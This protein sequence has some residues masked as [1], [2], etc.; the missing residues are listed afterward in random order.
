[1]IIAAAAAQPVTNGMPFNWFDA[2]AVAVLGFGLFRGRRNGMSKE[3]L[4]LLEWLVLVPLCGLAY[5]LLGGLMSGFVTDPLWNGL[6]AY[7]SLAMVVFITFTILKHQLAEKLVKS[8]FFKSGEYYMGMLA[9]MVRYVCVLIFV[10]ALLNAPVYTAA[11][12]AA[13]RARDQ[14]NFGGGA[15][16][17][18][19][20]NY[21]PHLSTI[22]AGVFKESFLGPR[23]E[24]Y[25]GKL[26]INTGK[27]G[28][29]GSQPGKGT[30]AKPK[31]I[32]KIG[33]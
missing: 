9:G 13:Q 12:I 25:A 2:V 33:Y 3:L 20:G 29:N 7:L 4:P 21:F 28:A 32:I 22:Q 16:S 27:L 30:P 18:F 14:Q 5:P 6:L 24:D 23:I 31:P 1:M 10:L 19:S 15:G 17:G 8:D 26:L 11:D